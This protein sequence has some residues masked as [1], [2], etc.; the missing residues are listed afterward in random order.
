MFE[1]IQPWI[2]MATIVL[3]IALLVY[4]VILHIRL[5]SLKKKYD[6]FMQG[7]NGASLERKLS[8]EVSEIRDAA[9]GLETMLT[10]QAAI[11]NIQS[12]TIQKI[13]FIKY[14]AFENIGNDLSFA[15]TL[16][17]GNNNGICISSIYGRNESRIFSK[18]IVK[19]KSL[20]SLSQEELESLNEALGERT[21]EE[22]LTSAIVSK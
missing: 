6:F 5:G 7:D 12:N 10:E 4:C 18:P 16:L 15:L 17:D 1:S 19:G 14:N 8:V 22:A 20:V 11:R 21:N 13:G 3:V 9:K 2:G